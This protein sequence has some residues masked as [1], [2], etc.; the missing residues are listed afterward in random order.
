MLGDNCRRIP[1]LS[2]GLGRTDAINSTIWGLLVCAGELGI[3]NTYFEYVFRM[4]SSPAH[5][6]FNSQHQQNFADFAN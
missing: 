5:T 1:P 3:L 6:I 2:G 4:P